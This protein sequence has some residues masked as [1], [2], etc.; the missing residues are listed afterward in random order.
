MSKQIQAY[1]RTEDDAEGAR[2]TLLTYNTEHL[3]VGRLENRIRSGGN[4]LVPIVPW[5]NSGTAGSTAGA[6]TIGAPGGVVGAPGLIVG[7]TNRERDIAEDRAVDGD[8]AQDAETTTGWR[9]AD[10]T[11]SD[12]GDLSYALSVKVRDEDYEN[13]VHELRANNAYVE[14]FE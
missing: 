14:R 3:E 9:E 4:I 2:T 13:I 12:Y 8:D 10:V 5:T 6:T 11:D 1:F 7:A